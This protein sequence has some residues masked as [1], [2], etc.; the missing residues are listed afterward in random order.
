MGGFFQKWNM[1]QT[2]AKSSAIFCRALTA[3][4]D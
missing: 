4:F 2:P 1:R 3:E